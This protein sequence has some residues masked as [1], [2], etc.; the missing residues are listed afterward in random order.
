MQQRQLRLGDILDDYCPRE[1]RVTNHAVVAMIGPDVKQTRCTTCDAEHEY[2]HAKV[3]RQRRKAETPA[4]LY[5]QVLA[6]G[7]KRVAHEEAGNNGHNHNDAQEPLE[8]PHEEREAADPHLE[9]DSGASAPIAAQAADNQ[10]QAESVD[11]EGESLEPDGESL[12]RE[13]EPIESKGESIEPQGE[14]IKPQGESIEPQ[15]ESL[16]PD[17]ESLEPV[18][19]DGPVHRPLIRASLPRPEGQ[20]PPTRPIPEFTIRQP[21][22]RPNRFRP[23]HQRGGQQQPFGS[24]SNGNMTGGPP[25]GGMRQGGGRP[26]QGNMPRVARRHGPPGRKRSK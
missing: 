21:G 7:P 11:Q 6:G 10:P 18:E 3:P 22:G 15:G 16:E 13:S 9:T 26:P 19:E 4:A 8:S 12:E 1:R 2:K 23:R 20:P 25:R 17:G 24:R 14:S 5:S